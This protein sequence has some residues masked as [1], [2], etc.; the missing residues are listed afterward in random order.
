MAERFCGTK[1]QFILVSG[2]GFMMRRTHIVGL[3]FLV[4]C[5]CIAG[6]CARRPKPPAIEPRLPA[7]EY[8]VEPTPDSA[9][10][11]DDHADFDTLS[12]TATQLP[13]EQDAESLDFAA[14]VQ[15]ATAGELVGGTQVID[16]DAN[17]PLSSP[18]QQNKLPQRLKR[19][20][21]WNK[22]AEQPVADV[23]EPEAEID[24]AQQSEVVDDPEEPEADGRTGR[25]RGQKLLSML[26]LNWGSE[27]DAPVAEKDGES[28]TSDAE[29]PTDAESGLDEALAELDAEQTSAESE[30]TDE[31]APALAAS[32]QREPM[33][34]V[35][36]SVPLLMPQPFAP[37]DRGPASD[38]PRD[39]ARATK[40]IGVSNRSLGMSVASKVA[41]SRDTADSDTDQISGQTPTAE[42][43]H[44]TEDSA[45]DR[46]RAARHAAMQRAI[47][48]EPSIPA[49]ENKPPEQEDDAPPERS[50]PVVHIPNRLPAPEL[51]SRSDSWRFPLSNSVLTL[52]AVV[53]GG[54]MLLGWGI[55]RRILYRSE[56]S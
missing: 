26:L 10:Q 8:H 41:Q 6:G 20:F 7:G 53:I 25:S 42:T 49:V 5:V 30:A 28:E 21:R 50:A 18:E 38:Q 13:V 52:S 45:I 55:W 14:N 24:P 44:A 15:P 54:L 16:T 32:E 51:N 56:L 29:N 39:N 40:P 11:A 4:G 46:R 17:Q 47:L 37:T 23:T 48:P 43:R 19:L 31:T 34:D 33:P 22:D 36:Q 9:A 27:E 3:L 1:L 2:R 35:E 12:N